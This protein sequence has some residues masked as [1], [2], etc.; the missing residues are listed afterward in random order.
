MFRSLTSV[1]GC[2]AIAALLVLVPSQN[3]LARG[4]PGGGGFGGG[5]QHRNFGGF[6]GGGFG[7]GS[8]GSHSSFFGGRSGFRHSAFRRSGYGGFGRGHFMH[9]SRIRSYRHHPAIRT[10]SLHAHHRLTTAHVAS[11]RVRL[12]G[13]P[14]GFGHGNASWKQNGGTPHGWS[15]G[16]KTGWGCSP[17]SNGC[18]PPG[19]AKK[20]NN[21]LQPVSHTVQ[22]PTPVSPHARPDVSTSRMPSTTSRTP[23]AVKRAPTTSTTRNLATEPISHTRMKPISGSPQ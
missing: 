7:R 19:L 16:K 21:G 14:T 20:S 17:G 11:H 18:M 23:T 22:R 12:S 5:F 8:F 4:G 6:H 3:V 15:Q 9:A 1:T 13:S 2:A 10:A